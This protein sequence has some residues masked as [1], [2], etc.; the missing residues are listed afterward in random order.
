MQRP[1]VD[2]GD[3]RVPLLVSERHI[4]FELLY[5]DAAVDV[6]RRHLT[7]RHTVLDGACPG[8]HLLVVDERHRRDRGWLMALLTFLLQNRGDILGNGNLPLRSFRVR[9]RLPSP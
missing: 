9:L 3:D 8:A 2:P 1:T 7:R 6:P 4:V 5:A